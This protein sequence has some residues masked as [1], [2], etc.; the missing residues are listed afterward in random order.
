MSYVR[1]YLFFS[2]ICSRFLSR[3]FN[4][5][6]ST[7]FKCFSGCFLGNVFSHLYCYPFF[8]CICSCICRCLFCT[9]F[10]RRGARLFCNSSCN[11][12][13]RFPCTRFH[14]RLT[15][16]RRRFLRNSFYSFTCNLLRS[17]R[18][19]FFSSLISSFLCSFFRTFFGS[20]PCECLCGFITTGFSNLSDSFIANLLKNFFSSF[21]SSFRCNLLYSFIR[22]L[23]NSRLSSFPRG[24]LTSCIQP[25]RRGF[26]SRPFTSFLPSPLCRF[27][28]NLF[29]GFLCG[30]RCSRFCW[31]YTKCFIYPFLKYSTYNNR[32]SELE[33]CLLSHFYN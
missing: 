20:L 2:E 31:F 19:Y 15:N 30:F 3:R 6:C 21:F 26:S 13:S 18:S 10:D 25:S 14:N 27:G 33:S 8:S 11:F 1:C 4:C 28:Y 23:C 16:F 32:G 7:R 17:F 29:S 5:L 12:F 9:C 22:R 24:L